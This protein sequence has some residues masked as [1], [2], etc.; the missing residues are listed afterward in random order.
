[1]QHHL[2]MLYFTGL[3]QLLALCSLIF[4][5]AL[6]CNTMQVSDTDPGWEELT[7]ASVMHLCPKMGMQDIGSVYSDQL[8][9]PAN[10]QRLKHK[11][12]QVVEHL[13]KEASAP[14]ASVNLPVG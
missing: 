9:I 14:F 13:S 11:V 3:L 4:G 2:Y 7:E 5:Q 10:S 12:Q 1:M 8:A 6:R